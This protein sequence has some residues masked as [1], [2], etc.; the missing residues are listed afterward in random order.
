[1]NCTPTTFA[2]PPDPK[3]HISQSVKRSLDVPPRVRDEGISLPV[4]ANSRS[5]EVILLPVEV[6]SR[7][8]E[9]SLLPVEVSSRSCE[10]ILLPIEEISCSCEERLLPGVKRAHADE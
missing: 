5:C 10:V 6:N 8:C 3:K 2:Y 4:E 1:M 9:V 7:S